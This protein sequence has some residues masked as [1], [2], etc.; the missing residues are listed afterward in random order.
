M[1]VC[2]RSSACD[3]CL[4]QTPQTLVS[5][6]THYAHFVV[7]VLVLGARAVN[8]AQVSNRRTTMTIGVLLVSLKASL[9]T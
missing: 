4:V 8:Y 3:F 5:N 9:T 7:L 2:L 1:F 6:R